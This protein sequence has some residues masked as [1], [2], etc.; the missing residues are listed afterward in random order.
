VKPK[1]CRKEKGPLGI[2]SVPTLLEQVNDWSKAG[3]MLLQWKRDDGY[4]ERENR[5]AVRLL[6]HRLRVAPRRL[7][8][9]ARGRE[10]A[11]LQRFI[12]QIRPVS[13]SF[14]Q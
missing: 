10:L 12:V 14:P 7:L 9:L 6:E 4:R 5:L 1:A 8:A 3:R 11:D 2:R 13:T